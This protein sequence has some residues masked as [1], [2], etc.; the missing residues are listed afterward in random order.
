[1]AYIRPKTINGHVYFYEEETRRIDGKKKTLHVRY[2]GKTLSRITGNPAALK[3][4]ILSQE[5][6]AAAPQR[7]GIY[8]LYNQAGDL[9]YIGKGARLRH[10]IQA[11]YQD[12]NFMVPWEERLHNE[13]KYF[14]FRTTKTNTA[15]LKLERKEITKYKPEY[16]HYKNNSL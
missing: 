7:P 12:N 14:R 3:D 10:R 16:N 5:N 8:Y 4:N 13:A 9:I 6:A 2:I 11:H 1:M 15:A